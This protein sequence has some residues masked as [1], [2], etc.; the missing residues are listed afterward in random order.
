[1]KSWRIWPPAALLLLLGACSDLGDPPG[2]PVDPVGPLPDEVSY[3]ADVQPVFAGHCVACHGA[4]AN[5]GLDLRQAQSH[6]NLVDVA[7]TQSS[8]SRV[9]PGEP[10]ASWLYL[11]V[12]GQQDIGDAMPPGAPLDAA[13]IGLIGR[14]IE[15]GAL[16]N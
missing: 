8:L 10:Q 15:Q 4:V 14:W 11:K 6:A 1:M 9:A 2:N 12:T 3:T 13:D 7:S 5:A 16:A